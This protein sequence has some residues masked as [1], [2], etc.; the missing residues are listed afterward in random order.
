MNLNELSQNDFVI[1]CATR[2]SESDMV[3]DMG[4]TPAEAM[5][6]KRAIKHNPAYFLEKYSSP[7][8][9]SFFINNSIDTSKEWKRMFVDIADAFADNDMIRG[10]STSAAQ[11]ACT[12]RLKFRVYNRITE[13]GVCEYAKSMIKE[14]AINSIEDPTEESISAAITEA[15]SEPMNIFSNG[16]KVITNNGDFTVEEEDEDVIICDAASWT[17]EYYDSNGSMHYLHGVNSAEEMASMMSDIESTIG[18]ELEDE[19]DDED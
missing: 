17:P 9:T 19:D 4:Y 14:S 6:V 1:K 16:H 13:R 15:L 7:V 11:P 18:D 2:I 3:S 10:R 8:V 12:R 5:L